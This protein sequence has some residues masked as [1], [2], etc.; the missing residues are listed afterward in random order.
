MIGAKE[1]ERARL[2]DAYQAGL[3]ELG[4]LTRR[5]GALTA[6][7]GELVREKD[8]LTQRSA[9]LA[10]VFRSSESLLLSVWPGRLD[11]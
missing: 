5:T 7:R 3:M 8:T 9:E 6:R 1:R 11:A 4:E 10:P 2:L